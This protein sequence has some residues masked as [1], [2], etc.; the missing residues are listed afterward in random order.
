VKA[1]NEKT[2]WIIGALMSI[3]LIPSIFILG[4]AIGLEMS[5]ESSL[6]ELIRPPII[7]W[8]KCKP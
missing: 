5:K 7:T 4:L 2:T 3:L 1:K 8:M 6:S